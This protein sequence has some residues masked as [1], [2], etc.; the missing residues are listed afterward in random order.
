MP[1]LKKKKDL[2][3]ERLTSVRG[4]VHGLPAPSLLGPWRAG[5]GELL[6]TVAVREGG[7]W[8]A[9]LLGGCSPSQ[10]GSS[11]AALSKFSNRDDALPLEEGTLF[12]P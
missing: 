1:D 11:L 3:E 2:K 5:A 8:E 7:C 6:L 4:S 9:L 12:S 10:P